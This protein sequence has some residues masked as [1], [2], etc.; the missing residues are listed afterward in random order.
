MNRTTFKK[1]VSFFALASVF[2]MSGCQQDELVEESA[3]LPAEPT[4]SSKTIE[5]KFIVVLKDNNLLSGKSLREKVLGKNGLES[6]RAREVFQGAFNGF[7]GSFSKDEIA[8]LRADQNVAFIE[9]D[10]AVMLGKGSPKTSTFNTSSPIASTSTTTTT[11]SST[12]TQVIPWGVSRVGYGD[13]TGKTV[14]VI[15][16]GVQ[17]SHPDLNV[18]KTRS[19]SFIYGDASYEDGYGHGTGVAGIIGAKNNNIGVVG[20]AANASIVALRVFDNTGYG[21][22]TRIY[23]ALNHVYKYG[24]PGDVVNMSLRVSA[25]TM[26]DDL[27]KKTAARGI[28]IAVASGNSYIDCKDDSPARVI[29]PNV[30]VVSNMDSY[31]RFSPSSNFGASVKFSAPGTNIQTTW[32]GG[33]YTTG[34]G[35]S[36]AAPH[37]AGILAL[38]GGR[39]NSQGYVSNDPD[40]LTDPIALK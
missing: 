9:P 38:T 32:K 10:Q 15:D 25:S 2:S 8:R 11:T 19:K 35:T 24:N 33:G 21:T 29:A 20:V 5:G 31:G 18:D 40:G 26:L 36:Y 39:V 37:V 1:A 7:S 4:A 23:S 12:S 28:F 16:S 14:W 34:N 22:L 3:I 30:F 17:S 13:G 27:V 6:S